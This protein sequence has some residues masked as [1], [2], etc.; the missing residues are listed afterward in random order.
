MKKATDEVWRGSPPSSTTHSRRRFL[1]P[2]LARL[3]LSSGEILASWLEARDQERPYDLVD[4]IPGK[5]PGHHSGRFIPMDAEPL[6]PDPVEEMSFELERVTSHFRRKVGA[7][8]GDDPALRLL[9]DLYEV[10]S[11]EKAEL[12]LCRR[13]GPLAKLTAANLCEVGVNVIYITPAGRRLIKT[14]EDA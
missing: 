14:I 10:G 2:S 13:C 7:V 12:D 9:A 11:M 8:L 3:H 6:Q 5:F 4:Y 1:A